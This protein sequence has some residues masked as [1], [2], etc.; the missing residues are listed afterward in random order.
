MDI[1]NN[2]GLGSD[3]SAITLL[4]NVARRKGYVK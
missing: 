1:V 4:A 3:E 2:T